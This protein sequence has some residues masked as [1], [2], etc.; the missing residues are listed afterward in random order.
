MPHGEILA[1]DVGTR[2][3]MG[4]VLERTGNGGFRILAL[5]Q[6]EHRDRVMYEGQVHDV[7][8]VAESVAKVKVA[9]EKR[10]QTQLRHYKDNQEFL[11]GPGN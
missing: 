6:H 2:T 7:A 3:I 4:L 10:R 9:L 11:C 1:L 5:E 8:A